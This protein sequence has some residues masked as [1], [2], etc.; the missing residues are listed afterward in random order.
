MARVMLQQQLWAAAVVTP[1][2]LLP[3]QTA[4][5]AVWVGFHTRKR[6]TATWCVGGVLRGSVFESRHGCMGDKFVVSLTGPLGLGWLWMCFFV[7]GQKKR[8]RQLGRAA[9]FSVGVHSAW[10]V[11]AAV[12][13]STALAGAVCCVALESVSVL[14]SDDACT[15]PILDLL[16]GAC[17]HVLCVCEK[18]S[19]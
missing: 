6:A 17:A 18:H 8:C 9:C 4:S 19:L 14:I 15:Q 16:W 1:R 11:W 7:K 13:C 12:Q 2:Q 10:A 3:V 5:A